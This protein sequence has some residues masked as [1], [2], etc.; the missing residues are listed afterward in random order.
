[1][2][3]KS[4][5][6]VMGA[7]MIISLAACQ[8]TAQKYNGATGYQIE[9]Q[10]H[11]SAVLSYTLASDRKP[12]AEERKLQ[13]ACQQVLG[14]NKTYQIKV[15]SSNEIANPNLV[16]APAATGMTIGNSNTSFGFSNSP[17]FNSTNEAYAARQVLETQ[18]SIFKVV[19]YSCQ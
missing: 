7:A 2:K 19:R 5:S 17:N 4:L 9:E 6:L 14:Q 18:P 8:S 10:D 1:M 11:N 16:Q 3:N 12:E 15:L 13:V